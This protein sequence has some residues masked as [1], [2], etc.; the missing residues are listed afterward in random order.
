MRVGG[1]S[2]WIQT[3]GWGAGGTRKPRAPMAPE[4]EK[5]LETSL[6]WPM[7]QEVLEFEFA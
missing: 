7:P 4:P 1:W 3:E 5:A 2:F 6:L